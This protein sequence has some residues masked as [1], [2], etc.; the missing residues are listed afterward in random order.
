[1]RFKC[2]INALFVYAQ[3][4][5]NATFFGS[6]GSIQSPNFPQNYGINDLDCLYFIDVET[7]RV[8]LTFTTFATQQ[9]FDFVEV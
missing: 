8:N 4:E 9:N 2:F 7:T 3:S 5:C 6:T 1:M